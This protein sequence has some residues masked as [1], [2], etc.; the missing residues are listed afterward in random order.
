MNQKALFVASSGQNVGK[1]TTCLGLL[2]G[3]R[4]R[5]IHVGFMKPVGQEFLTSDTGERA[6]KDVVLFKEHFHLQEPL[7]SM[8]P[9]LIPR[10]FTKQYL[11]GKIDLEHLKQQ[12]TQSYYNISKGK[13]CCI[14]EGTG[15]VGVGSICDLNNATVAKHLGIDILLILS[16]GLGSAFDTLMINKALCDQIG[17][18]IKGVLLNKVL[19][20]KIEMIRTYFSK[21]LAKLNIPLLGCIP[22]N[23]LLSKPSMLDLSTLLNAPFLAGSDHALF[24]A[25]EVRL[26]A[27]SLDRFKEILAEKQLLITPAIREDI[28]WATLTSFWDMKISQRKTL[29]TGIILTG[30]IPCSEKIISELKKTNIPVLYTPENSFE[31]TKKITT[32]ISKIRKEDLEKIGKAIEITENHIDFDLLEKVFN[33]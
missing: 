32:H 1:T 31:V 2:A 17:V 14:V 26:V 18:Q 11:D 28:I 29:E 30:S 24:H 7:S 5:K 22:F 4:K 9:I 25:K 15:H 33:L 20:E 13:T 23:P 16:G 10:G 12:I 19:P 3:L 6:D 8:S 27:T 21:A